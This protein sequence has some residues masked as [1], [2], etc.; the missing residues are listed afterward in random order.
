M[1]FESVVM[2]L[3]VAAERQY[4]KL[5]FEELV[6]RV[7]AHE[8]TMLA[9]V[10]GGLAI[11]HAYV[12]GFN[13]SRCFIGLVPSGISDVSTKDSEPIRMV[14]LLLSPADQPHKHLAGLATLSGLG[15]D[16]DLFNLLV[17]Q[18]VPQLIDRLLKERA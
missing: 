14:C 3:V 13:D 17:K 4:P 10:G 11:P 9:A 12:E 15:L 8:H 7:L 2:Q 18:T 6:H 1:T 16:R 5:P